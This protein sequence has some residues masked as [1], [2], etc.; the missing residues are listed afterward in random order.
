[1]NVMRGN[2]NGNHCQLVEIVNTTQYLSSYHCAS[3]VF[4]PTTYTSAFYDDV[5][6]SLL[7]SVHLGWAYQ[8]SL[9]TKPF[10]TISIDLL[11]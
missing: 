6:S 10:W 11:D 9:G 4:Y 8:T 7:A 1:M 3:L 2:G 5:S